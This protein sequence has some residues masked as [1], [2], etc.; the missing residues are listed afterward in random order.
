MS[1]NDL[2]RTITS[3]ERMI[4]YCERIVSYRERFG[5]KDDFLND[6]AYQDACLMVL[7]QIGEEAKKI[8][9]WLNSNSDYPWKDIVRFRDFLYHS[10]SHVDYNMIWG[11]IDKD[12]TAI[13]KILI[14]ISEMIDENDVD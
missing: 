11:I 12:I 6:E 1:G 3:I 9:V 14:E 4:D 8:I 5:E 2:D 13:K 10:Y 7:G